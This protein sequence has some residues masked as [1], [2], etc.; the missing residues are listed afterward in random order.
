MIW[1]EYRVY[2]KTLS[3]TIH[4]CFV[5]TWMSDVEYAWRISGWNEPHTKFIKAEL[6]DKT[7]RGGYG[8]EETTWKN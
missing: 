7:N 4:S 2:Y 8:K 5:T 3:G 1:T 6:V